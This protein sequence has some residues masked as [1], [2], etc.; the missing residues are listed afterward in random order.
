MLHEEPLPFTYQSVAGEMVK[1]KTPDG[2]EANGFLL[3]AANPS[4]KWLLVYQEWWG[5]NDYIKQEADTLSDLFQHFGSNYPLSLID[6]VFK[7]FKPGGKL[8][9][10]HP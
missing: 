8:F 9:D 6:P 5:L 3:K 2:T 10:I 1:F 4:N 7:A